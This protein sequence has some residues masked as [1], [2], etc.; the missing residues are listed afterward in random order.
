MLTFTDHKSKYPWCAYIK[1]KDAI[2]YLEK[3]KEFKAWSE[4]KTGKKIETLHSDGGKE[5]VNDMFQDYL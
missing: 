4:K 1:L 5:F 3:F 2:T